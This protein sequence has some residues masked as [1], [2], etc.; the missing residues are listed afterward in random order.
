MIYIR[1]ETLIVTGI[2]FEQDGQARY[3]LSP[4]HYFS[5]VANNEPR[6]VNAEVAIGRS[7]MRRNQ[8]RSRATKLF[9]QRTLPVFGLVDAA[10]LQFRYQQVD[11]VFEALGGHRI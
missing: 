5:A 3:F 8:P 1:V 10:L 2:K 11:G 7:R 9:A 4:S 6:R